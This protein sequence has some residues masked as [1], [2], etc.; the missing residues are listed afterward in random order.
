[1]TTGRIL[2][3][4]PIHN[5]AVK[6]LQDAGFNLDLKTEITPEE[7]LKSISDYAGLVVRSRTK[8]TKEVIAAGTSLKVIAR[9]GVGLDNVD[10][11]AAQEKGI[12]VINSPEGPSVSVAELVFALALNVLRKIAF[13]DSGIRRGEWLKKQSKGGEMRGRRIGIWGFGLIGEEV[14]KR[15]LAFGMEVYGFDLVSQRIE[16]MKQLGVHYV[17]VEELLSVSDVL[18]VHVPLTPKTRGLIGKKELEALP[19]GAIL[20]NTARGGIVDEEALYQSLV[21]GHLGGA[22]IDVFTYEPP[23]G[24]DLLEKLVAL[25]NVVSTPHIGAQTMEASRANSM[26]IAKKLMSLLK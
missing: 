20:I 9:A 21:A 11:E 16:V 18:T 7:L 13:G 14:A 2:V 1:M 19:Q 10:R 24:N 12:H 15:A 25:P 26:I 8:V 17:P 22:G 4:D 3:A 6:Q 5:D 23:F